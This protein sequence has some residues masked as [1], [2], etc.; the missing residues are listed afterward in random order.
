MLRKSIIL[1][2]VLFVAGLTL[3][4]AQDNSGGIIVQGSNFTEKLDWLK[5]FMR[6]NCNY[7]LEVNANE[8]I[9]PQ[10]F[11]YSGKNNITITLKGIGGNRI[12]SSGGRVFTVGSGV[13]LVLD[14]NISIRGT[15]SGGLVNIKSDGAFVMNNGSTV[16]GNTKD[17]QGN[18]VFVEGGTFTMNGGVI[19]G[20]RDDGVSM[21][22]GTFTM[23]NGSIIGNTSSGVR[24]AF[25][26]GTFTMNGGVISGNKG[27]GV[28]IWSE[29]TFTMHGGAISGNTTTSSAGGGGVIVING[30]SFILNNGEISG[31]SADGSGGSSS[32]YMAGFGGGVAVTNRGSFT[33]NGGKISSNTANRN[34]GGVSGYLIMNGGEISGN[35]A[36]ENGG[37]VYVDSAFTLSGGIVSNNIAF[38]NGGGV[39]VKNEVDVKFSK[40]GGTITGYTGNTVN[41]NV[42][43][44]SSG[45]IRN[46][47]GHAVYAGSTDTVLKIKESTAGPGDNLS[48]TTTQGY[49]YL[50]G[51]NGIRFPISSGPSASASGAWDN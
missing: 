36:R 27:G 28:A 15:D 43:K 30:G 32:P 10:N 7:I 44:G 29:G 33:M 37:G 45:T 40:T 25:S 34:G 19:S 41:G 20:N 49:T 6:S 38:E 16:T 17:Y 13:T 8:S 50:E 9:A 31:N 22:G 1:V 5:V 51:N 23:N 4:Q 21:I 24:I 3:V 14:N 39:Y 11:E 35:T 26:N 48:Y 18:G 2:I 42:V 47:R 46:F 12:I